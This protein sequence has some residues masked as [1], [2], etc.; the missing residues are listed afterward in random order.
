M[1]MWKEVTKDNPC[2]ICGKDSWRSVSDDGDICQRS[3]E[4]GIEKTDKNGATYR[5]YSRS[6]KKVKVFPAITDW[7]KSEV[8]THLLEQ[9]G[10]D[11][12]HL[13]DLHEK[14]GIP[15]KEIKFRQYSSS[16]PE[17]DGEDILDDILEHFEEE[18]CKHIPGFFYDEEWEGW[19][20]SGTPGLVNTCTKY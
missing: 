13:I 8:Y 10:L 7:T 20:L 19:F 14:R 11:K 16:Y 12:E 5:L 3:T 17:D 2:K 4:G 1:S 6:K 15:K 18:Q 9:L